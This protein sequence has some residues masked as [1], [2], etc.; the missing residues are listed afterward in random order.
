MDFLIEVLNTCGQH[1]FDLLT[2]YELLNIANSHPHFIP[3]VGSSKLFFDIYSYYQHRNRF[4]LQTYERFF[5]YHYDKLLMIECLKLAIYKQDILRILTYIKYANKDDEFI[6]KLVYMSNNTKV[7]DI[8]C[9]SKNFPQLSTR[10]I[11]PQLF[12]RK[13]TFDFFKYICTIKGNTCL[14]EFIDE[15]LENKAMYDLDF[16][17]AQFHNGCGPSFEIIRKL[18]IFATIYQKISFLKVLLNLHFHSI[19]SQP[20]PPFM[21]CVYIAELLKNNE[22]IQLFQKYKTTSTYQ[23][24]EPLIDF[25]NIYQLMNFLRIPCVCEKP[26]ILRFNT[27]S[28]SIEEIKSFNS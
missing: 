27:H 5:E 6:L 12:T 15:D 8:V 26:K 20:C 10:S 14:Y 3:I 25:N 11:L 22:I 4:V 7:F 23:C 18:Y 28:L 13:N 17:F 24:V 21:G 19:P 9:S 1:I 2:K 16:L